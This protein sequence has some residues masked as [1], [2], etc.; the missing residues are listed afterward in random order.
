MI[1]I[2]GRTEAGKVLVK[3]RKATAARE[4]AGRSETE[5]NP[6]SVHVN[7]HKTGFFLF[8]FFFSTDRGSSLIAEVNKDR[9]YHLYISMYDND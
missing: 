7:T 6:S 4:T 9:D 3:G 2:T 5:Q 8:F 1:T